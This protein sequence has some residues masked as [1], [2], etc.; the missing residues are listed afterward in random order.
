MPQMVFRLTGKFITYLNYGICYFPTFDHNSDLHLAG[1]NQALFNFTQHNVVV[2]IAWDQI[3][4]STFTG[5]VTLDNKPI[6][7]IPFLRL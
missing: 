4:A 2:K 3:L 5:P 1:R 7:S 6:L